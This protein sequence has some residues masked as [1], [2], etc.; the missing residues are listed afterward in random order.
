MFTG[1]KIAHLGLLP[2]GQPERHLRVV[3]MI[4]QMDAEIFGGC[5]WHGECQDACPKEISID[6]IARM[7]HDFVVAKTTR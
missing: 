6:T 1:A 3:R 7:N 4:D 5:T 2:Q